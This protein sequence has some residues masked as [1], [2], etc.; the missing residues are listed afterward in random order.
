[1]QY[2]GGKSRIGKKIAAVINPLLV[3]G[4]P[5]YEPFCG[6]CNVAQYI[7]AKE[8][9]LSDAQPDLIAMWRAL[10]SGWTPPET[11]T[12]AE[13]AVAKRGEGAPE[14]RAFVGFGCSFGGKW[15]GG[16]ARG[17]GG[18]YAALARRSLL[19]KL[20][21]LSSGSLVCFS[22]CD[23]SA[24]EPAPGCVVYCDPPYAHKTGYGSVGNFNNAEFWDIVR[25]W[26][27][28]CTVLVSEYSA[29]QDF[30]CVAEFPTKL[31]MHPSDH[32]KHV[33]ERLY[34]KGWNLQ[35]NPQG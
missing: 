30:E 26:S 28:R 17:D 22:A 18:N 33:T 23:Y 15:F 1:M 25:D 13:Y 2:L 8:R 16:Y 20:A 4:A 12:E 27:N 21:S 5:Y 35:T 31:T 10:Q 11:V 19:K 14:L 24:V 7:V 9:R 29:P 6:A 3:D 32:N 34:A